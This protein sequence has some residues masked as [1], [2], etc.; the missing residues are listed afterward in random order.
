MLVKSNRQFWAVLFVI[1]L[2][3]MLDMT[4][5]GLTQAQVPQAGGDVLQGLIA[6][7]KG[8]GIAPKNKMRA[9]QLAGPIFLLMLFGAG[10][11][12][13]KWRKSGHSEINSKISGETQAKALAEVLRGKD[14]PELVAACVFNATRFGNFM[15]YASVFP[16][17]VESE[18]VLSPEAFN[19]YWVTVRQDERLREIFENL[20][21]ACFSGRARLSGV[22]LGR[23]TKWSQNDKEFE[24]YADSYLM[25]TSLEG[26]SERV[27]LGALI[28]LPVGWKLL[29]PEVILQKKI[30]H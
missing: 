4:T 10:F 27:P 24:G 17:K 30:V 20:R 2:I 28:N 26:Q 13:H 18:Q 15:E 29:R 19:E 16:T 1:V 8:G 25:L 21:E 22:D 9:M 5:A 12:F 14:S 11:L 23:P 7:K 3:M 6:G